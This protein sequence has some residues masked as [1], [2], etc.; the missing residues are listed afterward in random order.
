MQRQ[1]SKGIT[2]KTNTDLCNK[3]R[4]DG[5]QQQYVIINAATW[6]MIKANYTAA[7][8]ADSAYFHYRYL[9]INPRKVSKNYDNP[10]FQNPIIIDRD[11]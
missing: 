2:F 4:A 7:I 6:Q 11:I 5:P 10:L 8:R 9:N 3:Q 1:K